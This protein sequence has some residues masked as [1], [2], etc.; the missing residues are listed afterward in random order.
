MTQ[1][2]PQTSGGLVVAL[3][4]DQA[5]A[6]AAAFEGLSGRAPSRIGRVTSGNPGSILMI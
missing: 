5:D 2:D 6:F 4:A 3:P 1:R